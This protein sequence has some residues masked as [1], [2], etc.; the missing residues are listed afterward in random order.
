[1]IIGYF[2]SPADKEV[3]TKL[4]P[5]LQE[6]VGA[7]K[8]RG[9]WT[10]VEYFSALVAYVHKF[11]L[12]CLIVT[13]PELLPVIMNQVP[14]FRP[15]LGKNGKVK[16][17]SM[18]NYHGS[19]VTIP[20]AA[21]NRKQ[22]LE[23]LFLN[24]LIHLHRV[25]EAPMIFKRFISKLTKPE[26]WFPASRFTWEVVDVDTDAG[27][28]RAEHLLP[29]VDG[30]VLVAVDCET[31]RECPYRSMASIQYAFLCPDGSTHS[32]VIPLGSVNA[33]RWM[34]KFN[35]TESAKVMQGGTYDCMYFLRWHAPL[36]NYR[37]DTAVMMHSWYAELPKRLDF[38]T[39]FAVRE[40]WYWKDDSSTGGITG[41]YEYGCKDV[42]ATLMACLSILEE[43]PTWA[44]ANFL[45]QFVDLFWTVNMEAD[46]LSTHHGK[47]QDQVKRITAQVEQH[48]RNL[49][50]WVGP[51]FN[52]RSPVQVKNLL[53]VFG[54]RNRDGEVDSSDEV[55]LNLAMAESPFLARICGEILSARGALKKLSTYLVWDKMWHERLFCRI[56]PYGTESGRAN[57]SESSY[58]CGFNG[59][60]LPSED[61]EVV[62]SWVKADDGFELAE[63]D[64]E[65]AEARCVGYISGCKS[66]IDLVESENDY[67]SWN[68][69]KF[70]GIPYEDIYDNATKKK[71]MPALRNLSKRVNHGSNYNM[72]AYMLFLTM[73][74]KNVAEAKSLLKLPT[75]WT[76]IQVC[77]HL[78]ATYVKAY[79]EVKIDWYAHIKKTIKYTHRLTSALGWTRWF[80]GDM[81]RSRDAFNSA[82]AHGPQNLSVKILN[83]GIRKVWRR[84]LFGDFRGLVRPKLQIHDSLFF[85]YKE[86]RTDIAREVQSMLNNPIQVTDIKG[87]TRTMLIPFDLSCGKKF[88]SELK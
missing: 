32:F 71:K 80:F 29:V 50:A 81:E 41:F 62:K 33:L 44:Q 10:N 9:A 87:V 27:R 20:A 40:A 39:V 84:T 66:L 6:M 51:N 37:Y 8:V 26:S 72:R 43:W 34:R 28:A 2:G 55:T 59:Q 38:V 79:P 31:V 14:G 22:D 88:W 47:F 67:H 64:G 77:D 36:R 7:H 49:H 30:A 52:P 61:L 76:A 16:K 24:P 75:S 53:W 68:A 18:N 15:P 25:P 78:L 23:I 73:G 13:N 69:S 74:P 35:D 17:L 70:F 85:A 42:W 83:R 58:W 86:G 56:T 65:Q 4:V 63:A 19:L 11:E 60:N 3:D 1:M 46:G 45:E 57:S 48:I 12:D 21:V 82:V 54:Y 5:R